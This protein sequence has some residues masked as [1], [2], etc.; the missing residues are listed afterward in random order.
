MPGEEFLDGEAPATFALQGQYPQSLAATANYNAG[1]V[2]LQDLARGTRAFGHY[3]LPDLE[4]V[5]LGL[6]SQVGERPRPGHKT[7]HAVP[8]G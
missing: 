1:F 8:Q 3:R 6:A 5:R 7:P 2:G 4:Q